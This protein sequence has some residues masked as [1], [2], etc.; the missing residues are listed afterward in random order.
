MH[1]NK[2]ISK[3]DANGR[4]RQ[5]RTSAATIG[6]SAEPPPDPEVDTST[7]VHWSEFERMD[8]PQRQSTRHDELT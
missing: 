8:A 5:E 4:T 1:G 3:L 7:P 6:R 2:I